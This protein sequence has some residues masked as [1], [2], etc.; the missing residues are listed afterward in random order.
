MAKLI[1]LE[2]NS[3]DLKNNSKSEQT[4]ETTSHNYE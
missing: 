3:D 4:Q 1:H 2:V